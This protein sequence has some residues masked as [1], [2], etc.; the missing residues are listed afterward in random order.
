VIGYRESRASQ[1]SARGSGRIV[2]P[3]VGPAALAVEDGADSA[4]GEGGRAPELGIKFLLI[5]L[6][7]RALAGFGPGVPTLVLLRLGQAGF[8]E[9]VTKK[10]DK[11]PQLA[12]FRD[13]SADGVALPAVV[14]AEIVAV[15]PR[16]DGDELVLEHQRTQFERK[17]G[18]PQAAGCGVDGEGRAHRGSLAEAGWAAGHEFYLVAQPSGAVVLDSMSCDFGK[19]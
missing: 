13:Q 3:D 9:H 18:K 6:L 4:P 1:C 5:L 11:D 14:G 19:C 17:V 7:P 12:I 8:E 15:Q 16:S 10:Q 2:D